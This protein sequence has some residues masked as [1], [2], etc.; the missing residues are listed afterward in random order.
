MNKYKTKDFKR[1]CRVNWQPRGWQWVDPA[2]EGSGNLI[3]F[4][5]GSK[6]LSSIA[7]EQGMDFEETVEQIQRDVE[8]A[9]EHGIDVSG[10]FKAPITMFV[11]SNDDDNSSTPPNN[12]DED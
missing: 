1:L 12:E 9:K 2:K 6:S 5:M 7:A 4:Q 10:L 8:Y 3:A 11:D